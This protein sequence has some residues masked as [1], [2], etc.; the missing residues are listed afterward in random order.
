[1]T[2]G[3]LYPNFEVY[4]ELVKNV[5]PEDRALEPPSSH[6][7]SLLTAVSLFLNLPSLPSNAPPISGHLYHTYVYI[8]YTPHS[9]LLCIHPHFLQWLLYETDFLYVVQLVLSLQDQE[10]GEGTGWFF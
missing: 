3:F 1:M 5:A 10:Y 7:R 8:L 9:L 4:Q 6:R 2:N